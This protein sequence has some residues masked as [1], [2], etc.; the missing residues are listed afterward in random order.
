MSTKCSHKETNKET[1]SCYS[2]SRQGLNKPA[3]IASLVKKQATTMMT[4]TKTQTKATIKKS[5]LA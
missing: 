4:K 3:A 2:F 1:S 5:V